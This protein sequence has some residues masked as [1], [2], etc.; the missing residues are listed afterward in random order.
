MTEKLLAKIR[1]LL[2]KTVEAGATEAEELAAA[3]K[4]RALLEQ[5]QLDLGAEQLKREGFVQKCI[6]FDA[7][8]FTFARRIM[9]AIDAFCEVKTWY[10]TFGRSRVQMEILGLASDAE[11]AAYLIESLTNFA[12]AGATMHVATARKMAIALGSPLD[13]AQS[14]EERRSYLIGCASRIGARLH[15]LERQRRFRAARPGSCRALVEIDKP[16][17]IRAEMERLE[18]RLHSGSYVTGAGHSGAFA[19]GSAHGDKA[20]FG[21]PVAGGITGLIGVRK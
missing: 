20:S 7:V 8:R 13:A 1:A 19:A 5:Y 21:R 15:E 2:A 10:V 3:E 17:L 12:L 6:E 4:A 16:D 18:I 9:C 11:F 14:R